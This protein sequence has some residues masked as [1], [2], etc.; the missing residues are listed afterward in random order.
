MKDAEN[1]ESHNEWR[2][3]T[4]NEKELIRR[5][6]A[7]VRKGKVDVKKLKLKLFTLR[8][9]QRRNGKEQYGSWRK[10]MSYMPQKDMNHHN[11]TEKWP[12]GRIPNNTSGGTLRKKTST[13]ARFLNQGAKSKNI[14]IIRWYCKFLTDRN[15]LLIAPVNL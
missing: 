6:D 13:P 9:T 11:H 10:I 14:V 5:Q 4:V 12:G 15:D 2:N 3:E 7:Y 1:R 8:Q